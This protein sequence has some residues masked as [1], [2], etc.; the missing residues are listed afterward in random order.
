MRKF[1]TV[2]AAI[3]LGATAVAGAAGE[4]IAL[5][6]KAL[7][8]AGSSLCFPAVTGMEDESLQ[9]AVNSRIREDLGW[10]DTCSG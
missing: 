4:E 5:E 7:E 3:C 1:L 8:L 2:L 6:E 9:E 10:T